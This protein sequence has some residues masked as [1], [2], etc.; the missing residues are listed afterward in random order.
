[1]PVVDSPDGTLWID[2]DDLSEVDAVRTRLRELGVQVTAL[3]PDAACETVVE[4]VS[5]S[6]LY[7]KIVPRNGPEPGIIVQPAAIPEGHTLLIGVHSINR[8]RSARSVVMVLSLIRGPAPRCYREVVR[9]PL[10]PLHDSRL[11]H[12]KRLA[13]EYVCPDQ[14]TTE[15]IYRLEQLLPHPLTV[16]S[17]SAEYWVS[18]PD[19]FDGAE[20]RD[21]VRKV[22]HSEA[23]YLLDLER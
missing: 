20:A 2:V 17:S 6:E 7:P 22:I 1:M 11:A 3:V 16:G 19:W 14:R 9:P 8:G 15:Q 23:L 4:E 21:A 10:P 5:W 13:L 12:A 18:Y